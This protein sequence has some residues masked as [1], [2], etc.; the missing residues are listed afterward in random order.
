[1][2]LD[3]WPCLYNKLPDWERVLHLLPGHSSSLPFASSD[4]ASLHSPHMLFSSHPVHGHGFPPHLPHWRLLTRS[5]QCLSQNTKRIYC[6]PWRSIFNISK[7]LQLTLMPWTSLNV[8]FQCYPSPLLCSCPVLFQ[9]TPVM[10][11]PVAKLYTWDSTDTPPFL[12]SSTY[13][14]IKSQELNLRHLSD[15][16]CLPPSLASSGLLC[17]SPNCTSCFQSRQSTVHSPPCHLNYVLV[18]FLVA[19]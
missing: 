12:L 4:S 8:P 9:V 11:H 19:W 7:S 6:S 5:R 17:P 15:L 1:M 14:C 13:H 16:L 18:T 3:I 2:Y 10:T